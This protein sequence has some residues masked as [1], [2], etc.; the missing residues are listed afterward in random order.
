MEEKKEAENKVCELQKNIEDLEEEKKD[1]IPH[2][3]I[4]YANLDSLIRV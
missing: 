3:G 1:F 4:L 2:P